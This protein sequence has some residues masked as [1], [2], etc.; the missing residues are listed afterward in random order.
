MIPSRNNFR[1]EKIHL[2]KSPRGSTAKK[3]K[4]IEILL[5]T[6]NLI[7]IARGARRVCASMLN[8]VISN[9]Y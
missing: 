8:K 5:H 7:S 3:L 1:L 4:K 2:V 9:G 6:V